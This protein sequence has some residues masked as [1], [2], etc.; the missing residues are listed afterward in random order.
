MEGEINSIRETLSNYKDSHPNLHMLWSKYLEFKIKAVEDTLRDLK[1]ALELI[2]STPD[3]GLD[4]ILT[5]YCL[6]TLESP[7]EL[8]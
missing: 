2:D 7:R 4:N 8:T 5:L 1:V 3:L 6:S